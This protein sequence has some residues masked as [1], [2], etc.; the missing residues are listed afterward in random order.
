MVQRGSQAVHHTDTIC[1]FCAH[2]PVS[3]LN[4]FLSCNA[5][6]RAT[7]AETVRDRRVPEPRPERVQP[8]KITVRSTGSDHSGDGRRVALAIARDHD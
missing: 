8:V 7:L 5:A 1:V 3:A 2:L 6:S 4:S